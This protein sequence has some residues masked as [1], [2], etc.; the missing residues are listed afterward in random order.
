MQTLPAKAATSAPDAANMQY[1]FFMSLLGNNQTVKNMGFGWVEYGIFWSDEEPTQGNYSWLQG[2]NNVDN[3]VDGARNANLNILIR[4]S[5]T[6]AWARDGACVGSDTCPPANPDDFGRFAGAL[7]AR[8]RSHLNGQR[9]AY[10]LWNEPN[11]GY[12]WGMLCPDPARYTSLLRSAYPR[13]KTSDSTATIA[14][15]SLTTVAQIRDTVCVMDD[16]EFLQGMYNAGAAPYFDVL[17]D[18]PYGFAY[19][20]EQDPYTGPNGL[21]FRRAERHHDYM[22]ANGD[23]NK[24][25]W[26]T[27]MGWAID[28][29]TEGAPC[30]PPDWYFVFNQQQQSDYL[31]R[32]HQ[33]ARSYWPWMEAMFT[34]NFDFNEAPWYDV[35]HPFR[36][37]AVKGRIAQGALQNFVHNPPPTYTP[38]PIV[39]TAT[40]T[41]TST[42]AVDG[43]PVISAVRYSALN[44]SRTGGTLTVDLDAH[45]IDA[46]PIDT[47]NVLVT[48]PGGA[49]Q[50][51]VMSLV[52][53]SAQN[54]TWRTTIAI[55]ANNGPNS[56]QYTIA[57]YVVES[58][59]P[60]RTTN[61]PT[62]LITVTNTRFWDV[63][64]DFWAYGF[65]EQLAARNVISGY[66]DASF[67]PGNTATRAQLSK[68]IVLAFNFAPIT[69]PAARFSD[70][71]VGSTFFTYVE[72]AAA[73]N[74]LSGYPCGA[75][76]EP[77]DAQRRPYFRP[78]S[79]VTR[80]QIAK[81]TV[82]AT[83]WPLQNPTAATFAD[84][85]VGSTFFP[86]I[87]TAYARGLLTGYPCGAPGEP[88]DAQSR[89]YF[90]QN[91]Q[92]S[93]A[94]ICK[95]VYLASESAASPTPASA[96]RK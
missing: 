53:G 38:V 95:I 37:F 17:S 86:Y 65:I 61:A 15:G 62:Q 44:F 59:P 80:A 13:M 4:I 40:P 74:L 75:P 68:I 5:R 63:P 54:G 91:N 92:A 41:R 72:T 70:V 49:T 88:C 94:Q 9:V 31:V 96:P 7:A 69:P 67:R 22:V 28:P 12:E 84:V 14:G 16:L 24:K 71:P 57:P 2:A 82:L 21:V 78:G 81:I 55:A 6:P 30:Q 29:R 58:F 34:W 32:A 39:G 42:P 60:R 1:G 90:R 8:V 66:S 23:G 33:W 85:P 18:H 46:T 52:S 36:Y 43:P 48:Y 19:A 87:E 51:F 50:L 64:V 35:C 47:A 3:I 20:P 77:C 11:T 93:R 76:G 89:P 56:V 25:I 26:A 73:R 45:D 27:E 79:A 83:G 10:E